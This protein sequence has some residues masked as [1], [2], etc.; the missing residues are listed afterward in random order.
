[1]SIVENDI[2]AVTLQ[3]RS[4]AASEFQEPNPR[5]PLAVAWSGHACLNSRVLV[6]AR[7]PDRMLNGRYM[8]RTHGARADQYGI[9]SGTARWIQ[10][11]SVRT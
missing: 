9:S 6:T 5:N 2:P 3:P 1:M 8:Q 10:A 4:V 11:C 7:P